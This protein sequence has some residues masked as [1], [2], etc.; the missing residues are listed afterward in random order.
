MEHM[1]L[2][3]SLVA[4]PFLIAM[5][6]FF[7]AGEYAVVAAKPQHVQALRIR[8]WRRTGAALD[9]FKAK[10]GSAIGTI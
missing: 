2:S 8:G 10:P 1:P 3:W 5:N 6:A 9:S 7:V 4:V